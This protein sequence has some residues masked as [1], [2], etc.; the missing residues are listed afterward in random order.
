MSGPPPY[1]PPPGHQPGFQPPYPAGGQPPGNP[2]YPTPGYGAAP[3]PAPGQYQPGAQPPGYGQVPYQPMGSYPGSTPPPR[4]RSPWL[5]LGIV[6]GIGALVFV[7]CT[8]A[9]VVL[10]ASDNGARE[11]TTE[12]AIDFSDAQPAAQAATCEVEG[13]DFADDYR[14]FTTVTNL[15]GERS[16][17]EVRYQ[18]ID[19]DTI[20]GNDFGIIS[21]LEP[22]DTERD[23][24]F[25]VIG[26]T[27]PWQDITCRVT[28]TLRV[29]T[30]G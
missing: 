18:L 20:I 13:L 16:H 21:G 19:G 8:A 28:E 7:G 12:L 27:T 24:A 25:G 15:D 9:I 26:G 2:S 29:P 14:V 10:V 4:K 1:D 23:D 17:Y 3:G 30:D 11:F 22:G 5:I 6:L